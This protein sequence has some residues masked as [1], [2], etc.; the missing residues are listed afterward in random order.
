MIIDIIQIASAVLLVVIILLQNRGSGLGAAFGGGG[1]V[2]H[3]K[4]GLEKTLFHL[5]I[6]LA[7]IF[8]ITAFANVVF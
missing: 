4:R 7:I 1:D 6:A 8:F 2:Y 3:A 5:T